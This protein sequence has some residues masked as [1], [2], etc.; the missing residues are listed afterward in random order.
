MD[1]TKIISISMG[2]IY[3]EDYDDSFRFYNGVLGLDDYSPMGDKACYFNIGK[4]Q[5]LY[6]EGG[7]EPPEYGNDAAKASFTFQV[8]SA[9]KLFE[10]LRKNAIRTVQKEPMKMAENI[11]W[12]QCFD[13]SGNIIEFVGGE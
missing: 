3:A 5:G 2:S 4:D 11:F 9:S 1:S 12:F 6:L 7:Y 13:P 8:N 10:K